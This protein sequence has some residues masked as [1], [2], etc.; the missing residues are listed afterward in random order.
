LELMNRIV[1]A[2]AGC[3]FI[4]DFS[5]LVPELELSTGASELDAESELMRLMI[6]RGV[7]IVSFTSLDLHLLMPE[8]DVSG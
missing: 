8:S 5:R 3:Y 4:I 7:H 2:N 1:E 6:S